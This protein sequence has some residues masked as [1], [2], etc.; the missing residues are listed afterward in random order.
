M[1]L[2]R[3]PQVPP[4]IA[5]LPDSDGR[6]IWSVMIPVYNCI[7]YLQEALESVLQQ[8][9]PADVMQIMVIDDCS[10]DGD[11]AEL[12]SAVGKGRVGYF[13][14]DK[15]SGSLRNFESCINLAKGKYVHIL[16]GDDKVSHGFYAEMQ[17]LFSAYPEVGAC[18]SNFNHIDSNGRE[19]LPAEQL[20][21]NSGVIANWLEKI[22]CRNLI[23]PPA[24]IVKREVYEQLG[25]FFAVHYGE[26]WEMWVR[27]AAHYSCAYSP[28]LLAH[29]RVHTTNISTHSI[30]SG[31]NVKDIQKV[32]DIINDYLPPEKRRLLRN[33]AKKNFSRYFATLPDKLYH[34]HRRRRAALMQAYLALKMHV[35][36]WTAKYMVKIIVKCVIGY[37]RGW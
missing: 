11:V 19:V 33:T 1:D 14:K 8:A 37:R 30:R 35:N 27:I 20:Q 23:Q 12:V 31:Q 34:E 26:D 3:T 2:E 24:I 9:L 13:R 21:E 22:A 16:H 36:I 28:K 32:I 15:N 4:A 7:V 29:Y 6:V 25:S 18:Y 17:R 10:T 5:R